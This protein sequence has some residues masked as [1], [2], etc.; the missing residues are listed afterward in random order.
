MCLGEVAGTRLSG[1]AP[2]GRVLLDRPADGEISLTLR[3]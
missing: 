3:R 1:I 2:D